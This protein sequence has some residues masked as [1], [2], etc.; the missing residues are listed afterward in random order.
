MP[1]ES[2]SALV[3]ESSSCP[4]V[5]RP[6]GSRSCRRR[7]VSTFARVCST[8]AATGAPASL[9]ASRTWVCAAQ[10]FP[11]RARH[12]GGPFAGRPR[13]RRARTET[14]P[15]SSW[16][17]SS[18]PS[19]ARRASASSASARRP[20]IAVDTA[21]S[22]STGPRAHALLASRSVGPILWPPG[23]NPRADGG[24]EPRT[25]RR[26]VARGDGAEVGG[27]ARC[28]GGA[29]GGR[30]RQRRRGPPGRALLAARARAGAQRGD[31]W[32][33][34]ADRGGRE[35]LRGGSSQWERGRG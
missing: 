8:R 16:V 23:E 28:H 26:R 2:R 15:T 1:R 12:R 22:R 31:R 20:R 24:R 25:A 30:A 13:P 17:P 9:R 18:E 6:A 35:E 11:R 4:R 7:T 14:L 33:D 19:R 10:R 27:R 29:R 34:W 21:G 32:G 5:A 3:D